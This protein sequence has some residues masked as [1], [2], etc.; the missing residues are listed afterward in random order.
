MT[1][2]RDVVQE[3]VTVLVSTDRRDLTFELDATAGFESR[4]DDQLVAVLA[5]RSAIGAGVQNFGRR[6]DRHGDRLG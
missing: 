5:V 1:R 3:Q 4:R 2:Y 6:D